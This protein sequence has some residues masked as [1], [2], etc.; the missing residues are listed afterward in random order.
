MK[1]LL[2]IAAASLLGCAHRGAPASPVAESSDSYLYSWAASAD[3]ARRAAFL[4]QFDLRDGSPT[5]GKV[6]RV[7]NAGSGSRS[8]H[9][10]EHSM[11]ADGLFFADDFRLG[12]TFVFDLKNQ[13]DPRV[14]ASF[15]TAGPFGWPHS[16]VRLASGNRLITYQFQSSTFNLPPGGIA[17]VKTDGSIVRW[18]S[19]VSAGI[20]DKEITPYSLEVIP[21]LDRVVTT[22][23]SMIED[24]G[25]GI[26]VWSLSNL[27]LLHTLRIPADKSHTMHA[28]D[29]MPHH[30]FPGEPRVLADGRTVMFATFTCGLYA[31]TAIDSDN[32]RINDVYKFPGKDCAVPVVIGK[33]WLQTV[34]ALRAVVALDVSNPT[35]PR[36][37]SRIDLGATATPHWLARDASG[38]RLV[39]NSGSPADSRLYLLRFDE[40]TG[41][42]SRDPKF[43]V[44]DMATVTVPGIGAVSAAPHGTV[45]SR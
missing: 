36:E 32:P 17:E 5:A 28:A 10:S 8:T 3:T 25:V 21:A 29:T 30:L 45:F 38:Q 12:R 7:V 11:P 15:T 14:H 20:D 39:V 18:A 23:T 2:A 6:V 26:Q 13:L 24:T 22:S 43:P 37:V 42:L 4:V 34:P 31:L 40:A 33:Y 9:H 19:A 41:T 16:Y 35:A 1:L 44:L 27:K